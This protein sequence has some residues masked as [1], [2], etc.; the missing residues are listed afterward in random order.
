MKAREEAL[1]EVWILTETHIFYKV[2]S[3]TSCIFHCAPSDSAQRYK[4][5]H[6]PSGIRLLWLPLANQL[7][8]N[9]VLLV[10]EIFIKANNV[11][12]TIPAALSK[13]LQNQFFKQQTEGLSTCCLCASWRWGSLPIL[14][15]SVNL[16]EL[17]SWTN[18][19]NY[20]LHRCCCG[21][22]LVCLFS[23]FC[24][25]HHPYNLTL[26]STYGLSL[27]SL[28]FYLHLSVRGSRKENKQQKACDLDRVM[29]CRG[30]PLNLC[31]L[32]TMPGS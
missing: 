7:S 19:V 11:S 18:W 5:A 31:K 15:P 17:F 32:K 9:S 13:G 10:P 22:S 25:S 14:Q 27:F 23:L 20:L 28:P 2:A 24:F 21:L 8:P 12:K 26:I 16:T 29:V 30:V 4:Q 1:H 3:L 6:R